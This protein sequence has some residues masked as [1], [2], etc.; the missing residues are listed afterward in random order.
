MVSMRV[1]VFQPDDSATDWRGTPTCADC[2]MPKANR[3]HT[4][5]PVPKDVTE[6]EARR[7]G[8]HEGDQ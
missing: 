8:E 6:A 3:A 7:L 5:P 1:H 2:H 4:L